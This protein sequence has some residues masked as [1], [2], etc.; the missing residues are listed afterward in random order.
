MLV[1]CLCS[2][3]NGQGWTSRERLESD[4]DCA[5]MSGMIWRL[6]DPR[7]VHMPPIL[8]SLSVR[9]ASEPTHAAQGWVMHHQVLT[10]DSSI[11]ASCLHSIGTHDLVNMLEQACTMQPICSDTTHGVLI[12]AIVYGIK[13]RP[14]SSGNVYHLALG[15]RSV[16]SMVHLGADHNR[17]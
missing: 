4:E 11:T 9:Q 17:S 15:S 16:G 3:T 13:T 1:S 8:S 14:Q 12:T 6:D 7:G 2:L 5:H 10:G